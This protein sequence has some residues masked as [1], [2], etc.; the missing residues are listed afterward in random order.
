[1]GTTSGL[2]VGV[3][4]ACPQYCAGSRQAF[5]AFSTSYALPG[6][7]GSDDDEEDD[8]AC[9]DIKQQQERHATDES[10]GANAERRAHERQTEQLPSVN[11]D[12]TVRGPGIAEEEAVDYD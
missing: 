3:H 2:L 9:E 4:G 12:D 10:R 11:A 1:M 5:Y 6:E 8:E 7:Y